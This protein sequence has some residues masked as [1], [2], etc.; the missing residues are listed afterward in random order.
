[1]AIS[2][3]TA[4]KILKSAGAERISDDAAVELSEVINAFA[5]SV[6]KKAVMLAKHASRKTVK[7]ADVQ[8][9]K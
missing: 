2:R 9:A 1:M 4:K 8:L 5:Y 6:A 7:K 3:L